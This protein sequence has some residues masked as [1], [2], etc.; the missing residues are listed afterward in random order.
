MRDL[1][2]ASPE[3]IAAERARVAREGLGAEILSRQESDGSWRRADT[4]VWLSTLFTFL[5]L[6][7]TGGDPTDPAVVSAVAHLEN[8]L[9]WNDNGAGWNLRPAETGGNLFFEGEEEP[10]INDGVLVLG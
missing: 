3:T 6:R 7:S 8:N 2:D 4:R 10:C 5:L 9:R 1:T